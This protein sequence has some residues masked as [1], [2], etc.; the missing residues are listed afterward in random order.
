MPIYIYV[1]HL[2]KYFSGEGSSATK[3]KESMAA[4]LTLVIATLLFMK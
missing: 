1:L 3:V 2:D 4:T